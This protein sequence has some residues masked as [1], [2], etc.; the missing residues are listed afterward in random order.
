MSYN[1]NVL[2]NIKI[3]NAKK[4]VFSS[5]VAITIIGGSTG[6]ALAAPTSSAVAGPGCFGQWRA[7]SVQAINSTAPGTNNAGALYFSQR[8]GANATINEANMDTCQSL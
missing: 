3:T 6:V 8:A 4:Y 7:G 1:Y 2:K 5:L